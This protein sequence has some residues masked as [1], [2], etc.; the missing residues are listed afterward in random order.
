MEAATPRSTTVLPAFAVILAACAAV[1]FGIGDAVGFVRPGTEGVFALTW[2]AGWTFL[3]WSMVL[4]GSTAVLLVRRVIAWR[5]LDG[6]LLAGCA[7][8]VGVV[9]WTH[10]LWG[11]GSGTG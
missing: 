11:S 10:P 4:V 5:W 3:G 9:L 8:L 7:V 6:S 1:S 2:F